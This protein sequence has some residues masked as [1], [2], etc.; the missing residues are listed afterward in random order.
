[1]NHIKLKTS[2]ANTQNWSQ[3]FF[4]KGFQRIRTW[5]FQNIYNFPAIY[6]LEVAIFSQNLFT[7]KLQA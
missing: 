5:K 1:M 2:T 3:H 4:F 7:V 6:F